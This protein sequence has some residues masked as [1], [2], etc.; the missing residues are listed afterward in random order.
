MTRTEPPSIPTWMLQHLTPGPRNQALAGD[1]L[2]EFRGGR[3]DGWYRRQVFA[4][5]AIGCLRSVFDHR[6]AL[7]FAA[8]WSML[9]PLLELIFVRLFRQN[10]F[11]GH[12]WRIPWPWSTACSF[13]LSTAEDLLFVWIGA[14]VYVTLLATANGNANFRQVGRRFVTSMVVFIVASACEFALLIAIATHSTG[15]GVDLRTLTL[16]DVIENLAITHFPYFVGTA[17]ALWG[18]TSKVVKTV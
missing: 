18:A 13:G 7:F 9:S 6:I 14:L 4:A 12:I 3:S 16:L 11:I 2:E 15:R 1:L 10:N 5:I 17:C 8:T